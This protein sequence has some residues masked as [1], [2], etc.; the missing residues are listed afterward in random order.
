MGCVFI[1]GP[2]KRCDAEFVNAAGLCAEHAGA[3]CRICGGV[4]S[5]VCDGERGC[6]VP[7]CDKHRGCPSHGGPESFT[8]PVVLVMPLRAYAK[9]E[10]LLERLVPAERKA[11]AWVSEALVSLARSV[12]P[13]EVARAMFKAL[14][15]DGYGNARGPVGEEWVL[16]RNGDRKLADPGKGGA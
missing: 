16:M 1:V 2:A 6:V 4:V 10:G 11:A 5:H 14:P 3:E 7:L 13:S 8:D 9:L 15:K 12:A